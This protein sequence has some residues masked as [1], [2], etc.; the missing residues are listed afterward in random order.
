MN[1]KENINEQ[2]NKSMHKKNQIIMRMTMRGN[3]QESEK[4]E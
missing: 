1:Y 3:L 4:E 2:N